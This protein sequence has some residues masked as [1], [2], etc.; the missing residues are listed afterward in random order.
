[1]RKQEIV[2]THAKS[3]TL[4]AM[5]D[6]AFFPSMRYGRLDF[7]SAL[8]S[9]TGRHCRGGLGRQ[10]VPV[11]N[12]LS[13]QEV[14]TT[15]PTLFL[16][17]QSPKILVDILPGTDRSPFEFPQAAKM[18]EP[19]NISVAQLTRSGRSLKGVA[20]TKAYQVICFHKLPIPECIW[21]GGE[22]SAKTNFDWKEPATSSNWI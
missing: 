1:V 2:S 16:R 13:R 15:H 6:I 5:F 17:S 14:W 8:E 3:P 19:R 4:G 21:P 20:C 10:I 12:R 22:R 11:S 9:G 7:A 18:S